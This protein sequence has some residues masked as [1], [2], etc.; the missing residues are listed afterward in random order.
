MMSGTNQRYSQ[1]FWRKSLFD[2]FREKSTVPDGQQGSYS[3]KL[4]SGPPLCHGHSS[5]EILNSQQNFG[6]VKKPQTKPGVIKPMIF[7]RTYGSARQLSSADR[8]NEPAYRSESN[9]YRGTNTIETDVRIRETEKRLPVTTVK[10]VQRRKKRLDEEQPKL[11]NPFLDEDLLKKHSSTQNSKNNLDASENY[12][13]HVTK[14]LG[15]KTVSQ[16]KLNSMDASTQ[17]NKGNKNCKV[18]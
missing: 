12:W 7:T 5:T 8:R 14:D 13:L 16:Q 9:I 3:N 11:V 17:T 2:H 1:T 18:M 6:F 10:G 15:C 4:R